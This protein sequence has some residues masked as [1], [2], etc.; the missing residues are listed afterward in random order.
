MGKVHGRKSTS[1]SIIRRSHCMA[2]LAIVDWRVLNVISESW[3]ETYPELA[4]L[5]VCVCSFRL[6]QV[7]MKKDDR[8]P[9]HV[10]VVRNEKINTSWE[11][12]T[13]LVAVIGT[14][15]SLRVDSDLTFVIRMLRFSKP[16]LCCVFGCDCSPLQFKSSAEYSL[17]RHC[18]ESG[19]LARCN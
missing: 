14:V 17:E 11:G 5:C 8:M 2:K 10:S 19:S 18:H 13:H 6:K 15:M 7:W 9:F 16:F 4:W 3:P 1:L 12:P